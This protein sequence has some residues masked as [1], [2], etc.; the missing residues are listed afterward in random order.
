MKNKCEKCYKHGH[1]WACVK[2]F[3]CHKPEKLDSCFVCDLKDCKEENNAEDQT[4]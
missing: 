3:G 2:W 4:G 1:C